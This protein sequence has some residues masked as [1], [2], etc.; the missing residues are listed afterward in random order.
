MEQLFL[1]NCLL[2]WWNYVVF[3]S[4][5]WLKTLKNSSQTQHVGAA[6]SVRHESVI[7]LWQSTYFVALEVI[8]SQIKSRWLT[9][10]AVNVLCVIAFRRQRSYCEMYLHPLWANWCLPKD[11][12]WSSTGQHHDNCKR[13][14]L[15]SF[16]RVHLQ[17]TKF[18][19]IRDAQLRRECP[20]NT[21]LHRCKAGRKCGWLSKRKSIEYWV[22]RHSEYSLW[23][24]TS[25]AIHRAMHSTAAPNG[26]NILL[27]ENATE[28]EASFSWIPS[29]LLSLASLW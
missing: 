2:Y 12:I 6:I 21:S 24:I 9:G 4:C 29:V 20:M 19:A 10:T 7:R 25:P 15:V 18:V 28:R 26:L 11:I 23:W 1:I 3:I 5:F 27:R 14:S 13:W 16:V 22:G 8:R 17:L